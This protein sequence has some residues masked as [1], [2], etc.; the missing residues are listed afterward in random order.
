ME[1]YDA[2]LNGTLS[3]I[4][5]S[6]KRSVTYKR[7]FFSSAK[8]DQYYLLAHIHAVNIISNL[9]KRFITGQ[10]DVEPRFYKNRGVVLNE[11]ESVF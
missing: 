10:S 6:Q 3:I 4:E 8:P 1:N 9:T 11:N 2:D 5:E 7:G